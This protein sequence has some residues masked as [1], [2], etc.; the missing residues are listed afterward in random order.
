MKVFG[1]IAA[2]FVA[3]AGLVTWLFLKSKGTKAA[4]VFDE[5]TGKENSGGG[6]GIFALSHPN[7]PRA[8]VLADGTGDTAA[9][10]SIGLAVSSLAPPLLGSHDS[11]SLGPVIPTPGYDV[12]VSSAVEARV[13]ALG[14]AIAK[15]EGFGIPGALP[16][17]AKNPG[18]MK[19]GDVGN[20][21]LTGKTIFST[22]QD[23]WNALFNQIKLIISGNSNYYSVDD[24]FEQMAATWTG[25]DSPGSWANTV[26][27]ELGVKQ[28]D[29]LRSFLGV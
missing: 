24:T 16:T 22:A 29:T 15:A 5:K 27:A 2:A 17:R 19:L 21:L 7:P 3:V 14:H 8:P 28:S 11:S 25:N 13:E 6:S 1:F 4:P 18:D 20:G 9:P 23:G 12:S 10:P 26:T